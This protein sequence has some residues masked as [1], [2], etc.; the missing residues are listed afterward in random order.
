MIASKK[1][2][3]PVAGL[4]LAGGRSVRFGREKAV[5]AFRGRP[6]MAW[7]LDVLDE[8]CEAV[9]VSAAPDSGAAALALRLGR[10]ALI[11]HA[12]RPDGPL[13]GLAT[14]LVWAAD[15]GFDVL[16]TL[17][18]DTPLVTTSELTA[19]VDAVDGTRPAYATTSKGAH[20]LCAAWPVTTAYRLEVAMGG[21]RH[22]SVLGFLESLEAS[23][24]HFADATRFQNL[25]TEQDVERLLAAASGTDRPP[26]S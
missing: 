18:C 4:V 23:P 5:A 26:E 20:G 9:A 1:N 2:M 7:S 8:C 14:G 25:N 10:P 16:V 19:L 17:P 6:M 3:R 13:A 11:D 21:G 12:D 15:V 22:P 24:I